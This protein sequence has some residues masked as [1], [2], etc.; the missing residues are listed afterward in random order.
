MKGNIQHPVYGDILYTESA[1]TGKKSLIFNG[2]PAQSISKK[3]FMLDDIKINLKGNYFLGVSISINGEIIELVA[4]PK[5]YE[6]ILSVLPVI[7]IIVWGNNPALC[8]IFPVVGGAIGGGFGAV[9]SMLSIYLMKKVTKP[10]HKILIGI[11]MFIASVL[12]AS[13]LDIILLFTVL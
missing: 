4:K 2:I 5:W 13:I 10:I 3:E 1:W 6:I 7:F 11:G 12:T 8:F 9:V